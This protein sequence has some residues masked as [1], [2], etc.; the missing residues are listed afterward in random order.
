MRFRAVVEPPE[1]MKGLEVPEG[2]VE[3]LGAG[4]RPRV[5]I[6][7]IGHSWNSGVAIMRGGPSSH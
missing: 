2:I 7:V 1:S 3:A 4:Q 6:T 5:T